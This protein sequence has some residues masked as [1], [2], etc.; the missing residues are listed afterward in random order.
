MINLWFEIY[1][2]PLTVIILHV[3]LPLCMVRRSSLSYF[4][5]ASTL[6]GGLCF[7]MEYINFSFA[8][9]VFGLQLRSL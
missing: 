5:R 8:S 2:T 1:Q 4:H 3:C 9:D 7:F 6:E